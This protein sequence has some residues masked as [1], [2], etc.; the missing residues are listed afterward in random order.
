MRKEW[1]LDIKKK[2]EKTNNIPFFFK[3]WGG[4]NKKKT[5]RLLQGRTWDNYPMIAG[6]QL[7]LL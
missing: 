3:Q 6:R 1:I 2:C 7:Q 4:V 5:G